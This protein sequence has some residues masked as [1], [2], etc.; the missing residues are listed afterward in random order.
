M[1]WGLGVVESLRDAVWVDGG[2][3]VE[4][5]LQFARVP[6]AVCAIA[7]VTPRAGASPQSMGVSSV[8]RVM[9]LAIAALGLRPA[10]VIRKIVSFRR[11]SMQG[12]KET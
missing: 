3:G 7:S 6:P 11:S 10:D 5:S 12:R 4:S 2:M 1:Y 9:P 8:A